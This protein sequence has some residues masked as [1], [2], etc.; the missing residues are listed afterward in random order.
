MRAVVTRAERRRNRGV[1]FYLDNEQV[2]QQED[3][4]YFPY[5]KDEAFDVV[6]SQGMMGDYR[7]R[8]DGEGRMVRIRRLK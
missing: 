4:R 8:V 6:I 1:T 2:W 5:P 3:D 7:L